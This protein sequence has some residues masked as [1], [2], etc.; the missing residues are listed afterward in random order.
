MFVH[1][2]VIFLMV[3][4]LLPGAHA[5]FSH[6]KT[7]MFPTSRAV[8]PKRSPVKVSSTQLQV[9]PQIVFAASCAGAV[10]SYVYFNIDSIKAVCIHMN[11]CTTYCKFYLN[12]S[13]QYL[14][15]F[16]NLSWLTFIKSPLFAFIW[17]G[18]K[19]NN[20]PNHDTTSWHDTH[21]TRE[22]EG[23]FDN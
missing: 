13:N 10:F 8:S 12:V 20:R 19:R 17:L 9:L 15:S 2:L 5:Y 23:N 14:S 11:I 4:A 1:K 16:V 7:K 22:A 21:S 3:C 6:G 18:T